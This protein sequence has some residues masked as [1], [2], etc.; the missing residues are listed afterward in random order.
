MTTIQILGGKKQKLR[1]G[2]ILGALTGDKTLSGNQIGKINMFPM[3]AYVAVETSIAKKALG[4]ITNG[5]MKGRNFRAR[6]IKA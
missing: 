4:K 1:P 5:K 2:D 3:N 6:I